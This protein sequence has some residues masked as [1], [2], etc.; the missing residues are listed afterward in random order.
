MEE[1]IMITALI[2]IGLGVSIGYLIYR[3]RPGTARTIY[4]W[5]SR[6]KNTLLA[7][8]ALFGALVAVSS[9]TMTGIILGTGAFVLLAWWFL[10]NEPLDEVLG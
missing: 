2:F 10:I 3:Y 8:L 5:Y 1:L 9:G 6:S 7:V 4:R